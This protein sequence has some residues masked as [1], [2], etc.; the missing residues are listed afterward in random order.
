MKAAMLYGVKDLRVEDIELPKVEA[1][2]V[3]VKVGAATTCG[4][5]LKILQRGYVERIIKLPTIFGHEWAG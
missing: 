2:E 5:D 4:T 1:G 3:L